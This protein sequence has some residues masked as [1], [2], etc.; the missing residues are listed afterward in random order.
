M[1]RYEIVLTTTE[2]FNDK[3]VRAESVLYWRCYKSRKTAERKAAV[4]CETIA[5]KG[6]PVKYV[7]T[8]EVRP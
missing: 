5:M 7:T 8:A 6:S 3:P 2:Y 4:M 1:N